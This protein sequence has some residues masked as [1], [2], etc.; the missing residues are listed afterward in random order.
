MTAVLF[1]IYALITV[2]GAL[3]CVISRNVV[4]MAVGLVVALGGVSGLFLLCE[5]EFVGASQLLVYV[6]G[7]AVVL[8]FG[9]MLTARQAVAPPLP[10][11]GGVA[12]ALAVAGAML[13]VL[14]ATALRVNWGVASVAGA[15][16]GVRPLGLAMLG[17]R[18]GGGANYLFPF[19]IVSLHLLVVLVGAGYMARAVRGVAE[20]ETADGPGVEARSSKL[21]G[22]GLKVER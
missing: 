19:E 12:G 22:R 21:E 6:G 14:A 9:V 3:A 16:S 18:P 2:A 4:R 7:T 17:L 15:E 11:P 20:G 5:A 8:V 13:A 10:T 1:T